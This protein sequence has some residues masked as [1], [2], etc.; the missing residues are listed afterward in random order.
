MSRIVKAGLV[1]CSSTH[2][3]TA[4][5]GE[6]RSAMIEKAIGFLE[7]AAR[8]GCQVVCL[9]EIFYGP[10]FPAEQAMRWYEM[11]ESI[12]D[13]PTIRLMCPTTTNQKPSAT[14]RITAR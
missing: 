9:Q 1:P 2:E 13:G 10:Y 8:K 12:P 5:L 11:T 7:D 14:R 4:P 3:G 6:I